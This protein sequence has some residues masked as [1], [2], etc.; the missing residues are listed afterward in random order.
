[1][2]ASRDIGSLGDA[3][4]GTANVNFDSG[5]L[6]FDSVNNRVGIGNTAPDAKLQVTG[7]A[8]VSGNVIIGG[9]L[10]SANLT[11]STN[12]V[13][14]GTS[15]YFVA[16]GNVGIGTATPAVKLAISSTDAILVPVGTTGERPTGAT[17]YLRFNSTTTSFEGYNGTA[18]GSIAGN[19]PAFSAYLSADQTIT[20]STFT[21]VQLNAEL[22]DTN[23]NFDTAT[24]YRFTPTVAGYYQINFI[25]SAFDST[26]PTRCLSVLYKNGSAYTYGSDYTATSGIGTSVGSAVVYMNGSTDYLELYAYIT[27]TTAVISTVGSSSVYTNMSGA[28]VRAA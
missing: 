2:P 26:S 28:L 20:S 27:A 12:T 16:N 9:G 23:S 18:W 24:N 5:L 11:S 6:F 13:T 25:M 4:S 14:I 17:G 3:I 10:T 8:N 15:S 1:M 21:K 22:F 19:G 7:T